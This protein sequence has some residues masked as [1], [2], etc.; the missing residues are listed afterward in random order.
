MGV[1][2][3][4]SVAVAICPAAAMIEAFYRAGAYKDAA[5]EREAIDSFLSE[6]PLP[7]LFQA[8]ST[9]QSTMVLAV[10]SRIFAPPFGARFITPESTPYIAAG[11]S[12][13][14]NKVRT[15]TIG[16]IYKLA[17]VAAADAAAVILGNVPLSNALV[18]AIADEN[19][20]VSSKA[21][22][23]IVGAMVNLPLR[24]GGEPDM[25]KRVLSR[26]AEAAQDDRYATSS[27]THLMRFVDLIVR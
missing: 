19:V 22:D 24:S 14:D 3:F 20:G 8:I 13:S 2:L 21:A 9:P 10:I 15:A 12:H 25:A 1:S 27:S 26:A 23:S 6:V 4:A 17:T 5:A 11:L 16:I 18:A 7:E